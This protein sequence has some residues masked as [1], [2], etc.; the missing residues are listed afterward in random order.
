MR[1]KTTQLHYTLSQPI[2]QQRLCTF[3]TNQPAN[4]K[5]I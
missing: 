1:F 4:Q 3:P 5:G 2:G